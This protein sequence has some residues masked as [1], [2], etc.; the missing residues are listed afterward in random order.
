MQIIN[1]AFFSKIPRRNTIIL[2]SCLTVKNTI[3][4]EEHALNNELF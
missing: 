3:V 4:N 1:I 2:L